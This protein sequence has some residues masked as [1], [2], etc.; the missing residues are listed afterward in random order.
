M[1]VIQLLLQAEA[2]EQQRAVR[3]TAFRHRHLAPAPLVVCA[4]NLSGEAAAPLAIM[5]G[6]SAKKPSLVVAAEPRNRESRF[7]AINA[8][9]ADFHKYIQPFLVTETLQGGRTGSHYEY[10]GAIDAPQVITPNRATRDYLG[11]RIGRSLRYLGLGSTHPV[12]DETAW[13]GAHLSWLADHAHFPGQSVFLAATELLT[14]HYATGQSALEDESLATLLAWIENPSGGGL[15]AIRKAEGVLPFGTAPDPVW[16]SELEPLVRQFTL[17]HR[18]GDTAGTQAAEK[19]VERLVRPPMMAA[20]QATQRAIAIMRAIPE[21]GTVQD[22][23]DTDI[24]EWSA[25][26][27]RASRDIPRFRKRHDPILAAQRI[28]IWSKAL[29]HLEADQAFD[30]P[31]LMADFDADGQCLSGAVT[32]VDSTNREVRPGGVRHTLVPLVTVSLASPTRLLPWQ[33]VVWAVDRH[34]EGVIRSVP[35]VGAQGDAVIAIMGGHNRG[36][37]LPTVGDSH[38]F[39]TLSPFQGRPPAEPSDVPWTHRSPAPDA[40][41]AL[42]SDMAYLDVDDPSAGADDGSPDLT[43]D[44]IASQPVVGLVGPGDVPAVLL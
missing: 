29:E 38:L 24:R 13:T 4:Y 27:R 41:S 37:N 39:V 25:Y 34:V 12:P 42:V 31:L 2:A 3:A 14:Q 5:Y 15:G 22:R 23:W 32:R 35:P 21:A 26:C 7:A 16:E 19:Q 28:E 43:P 44:E 9:S 1:S 8:F 33:K 30:D 18:A 36:A 11:A 6:T 10:Q 20:Y 17:A 40:G